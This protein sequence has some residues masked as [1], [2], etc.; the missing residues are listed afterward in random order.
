MSNPSDRVAATV[1]AELARQ[2]IP[3]R[4]V[5]E[6]LDMGRSSLSRR[7]TG[8]TPFDVNEIVALAR[9]L[10]LPTAVLLGEDCATP[11]ESVA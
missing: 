11:A 6:A 3:S 7:L 9:L 4:R 5:R 2:R 8:E 1:R 10:E